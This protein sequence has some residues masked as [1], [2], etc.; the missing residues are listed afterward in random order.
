MTGSFQSANERRE[1][2]R[3]GISAPLAVIL[4]KRRI[5]GFTQNLSSRGVFF[6]LDLKG[7]AM[8]HGDIE[9]LIELPPEMT[10]STSCWVRCHGRVVRTES[11]AGQ[12]TGI[13]AEI[14]HYSMQRT[15]AARA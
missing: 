1:R 9:F 3:F 15:A 2:Q 10:L 6:H 13:G 4:G 11:L 8:I 7:Y 14:L 5:P 12:L